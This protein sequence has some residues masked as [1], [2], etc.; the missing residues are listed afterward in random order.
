M[1]VLTSVI[2]TLSIALLQST[3]VMICILVCKYLRMINCTVCEDR[4]TVSYPHVLYVCEVWVGVPFSSAS[5]SCYWP[6]AVP[7]Q[8]VFSGTLVP[9]IHPTPC[10]KHQC[11]IEQCDV[12]WRVSE[13]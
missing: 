7:T 11:G 6:Q 4:G 10:H 3:T 8:G 13:W 9:L 12:M 5:V 1:A 2:S